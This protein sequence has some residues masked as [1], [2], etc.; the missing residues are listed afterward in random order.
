MICLLCILLYWYYYWNYRIIYYNYHHMLISR[1]KRYLIQMSHGQKSVYDRYC[2]LSTTGALTEVA[3]Q[4]ARNHGFVIGPIWVQMWV[5]RG[6][7]S[8]NPAG[9]KS[10]FVKEPRRLYPFTT[11]ISR[12]S[13]VCRPHW[14][15]QSPAC[16][17]P[18]V[19]H[20]FTTASTQAS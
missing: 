9:F 4:P 6:K 10:G 11:V 16:T 19:S 20:P 15:L 14:N 7:L 1:R 5:P 12:E 8:L 13:P 17:R 18:S 2:V 3:S